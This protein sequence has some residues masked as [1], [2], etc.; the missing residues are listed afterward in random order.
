MRRMI[1]AMLPLTFPVVIAACA[2]KTEPV[3]WRSVRPSSA[4]PLSPEGMGSSDPGARGLVRLSTMM[5]KLGAWILLAFVAHPMGGAAQVSA[6]SVQTSRG[7]I[8]ISVTYTTAW[9]GGDET[10]VAV[11]DEVVDELERMPAPLAGRDG[12]ISACRATRTRSGLNRL[13]QS[14][15]SG[16]APAS[17]A[18]NNTANKQIVFTPT[19]SK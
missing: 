9:M 10:T 14:V 15:V 5:R 17:P 3:P 6:W 18:R 19:P 1:I 16:R 4:T 7:W 13:R 2:Q 8:G 12:A 11:I